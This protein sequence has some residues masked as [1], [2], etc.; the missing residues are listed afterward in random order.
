MTVTGTN[1]TG[2]THV[3][4]NGTS[5]AFAVVSD[6]ELTFTVPAGATSG[7]ITVVN[8][9]S[10]ITSTG[11]FTVDSQPTITSISSG[12]GPVGTT[13]T[14]TGTN[15]IRT[16]GVRI[17]SVITVPVTVADTEVT[18]TI[19]PARPPAPSRSS[20]STARRRAQGRSP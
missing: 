12:S 11:T 14:I 2:A 10:S 19:R 16:V 9:A 13:V 20:A 17:G 5:V 15:L 8:P 1:F 18:F 4:L 3:R 6:T 7:T